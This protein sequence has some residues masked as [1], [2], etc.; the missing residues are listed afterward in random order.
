MYYRNL[1]QYERAIE[2]FVSVIKLS[3]MMHKYGKDNKEREVRHVSR[4]F[5]GR[6]LGCIALIFER[7]LRYA[8]GVLQCKEALKYFKKVK[9]Y[10]DIYYKV[11]TLNTMWRC[12]WKQQNYIEAIKF[13]DTCM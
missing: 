9:L 12:Y 7:Q 5:Q 10:D 2:K 6:A 4:I 11:F 3:K 1:L 8:E 13:N